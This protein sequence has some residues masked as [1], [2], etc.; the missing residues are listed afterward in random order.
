[1]KKRITIIILAAAVTAPYLTGSVVKWPTSLPIEEIGRAGIRSWEI[2]SYMVEN[3]NYM[4]ED[5]NRR[6]QVKVALFMKEL[7]EK[8]V[9][10]G[11]M[12]EDAILDLERG[13]FIRMEDLVRLV[14]LEAAKGKK[15]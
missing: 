9:G 7:R 13:I 8:H 4:V 15:R 14:R 3:L 12:P 10:F 6:F 11:D 2:P 1:M 5:F